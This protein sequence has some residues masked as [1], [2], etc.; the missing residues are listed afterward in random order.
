MRAWITARLSRKFLFFLSVEL[1]T[2]SVVFLALFLGLYRHQLER[3][4]GQ[5]SAQVNQL[6]QVALENAMLKR[7]LDGLRDIIFYL[8]H[9]E[10]IRRVSIINPAGEIRFSSAPE[11]VNGIMPAEPNGWQAGTRF[12]TDDAGNEVL[13]SINPVHNREPC[14]QCHGPVAEHPV[15][16]ILV[17]DYDGATVRQ[18]AT[19]TAL[20]LIGSGGLVVVAALGAIWWMLGSF[21]LRP[22][23]RLRAVAGRLS[24]GD[25]AARVGGEGRDEL[26]QLGRSF[27]SMATNLSETVKAVRRQEAFLQAVID[28]VPDGIRVI[29]QDFRIVQANAAYC[30]QVGL[31]MAEVLGQPCHRSSHQRGEPCAATLVTCPLVEIAASGQPLKT[32]QNHRAADGRDTP[33]EVHAAPLELADHRILVIESIRNLADEVRFSHEQKLSALGQLAAGVAHEIRNPLAS[34]RL[35][36]QGSLRLAEEGALDPAE[37]S[38]YLKLVDLQVDKCIDVTDRLLRLAANTESRRELVA[39]N[40][41]VRETLSLLAWEAEG[42]GVAIGLDLDPDEPRVLANDGE[43]RMVLLNLAQNAFHAMPRGGTLHILTRHG[44]EVAKGGVELVFQDDGA[45]IAADA[46]PRV[47]DAF[48]SRRAN[49]S[50]GTGLGLTISRSIIEAFGGTISVASRPGEGARFTVWLPPPE[51]ELAEGELAKGEL[52]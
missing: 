3:E 14:N 27:D 45:G 44:A 33:V 34:V 9:Q 1:L 10:N 21:V 6:L 4:R 13:R 39:V 49:G 22:V 16:G 46:L 41:A 35:A 2:A 51:G 50:D 18:S 30:R 43:M 28:T 48:Y 17:V 31:S 24:E 32:M 7:D 15:N 5:A 42:A 26:A 23:E 38:D 20:M 37:L 52:G 19:R 29:D 40:P 36:L 12:L 8:G 25:L 47:F 11:T